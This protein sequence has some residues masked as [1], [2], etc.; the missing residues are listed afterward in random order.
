M[1]RSVS[2]LWKAT[3]TRIKI[4]LGFSF[5]ASHKIN[6]VRLLKKYMRAIC[7]M[8]KNMDCLLK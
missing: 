5:F 2:G 7:I 1:I 3:Q 4:L 8:K 6:F